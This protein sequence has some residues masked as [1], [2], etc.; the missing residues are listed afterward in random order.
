MK[1]VTD[2]NHTGVISGIEKSEQLSSGQNLLKEVKKTEK[3]IQ[4]KLKRVD[5]LHGYI[6]T[7]CPEK[8]EEY[9]KG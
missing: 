8:W 3:K 4:K 6:M 7:T 2:T 9:N 5:T 1:K